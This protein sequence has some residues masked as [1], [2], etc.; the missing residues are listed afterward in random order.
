MSRFSTELLV[1]DNLRDWFPRAA[2]EGTAVHL[3]KATAADIA[4][5]DNA[6][7]EAKAG[8]KAAPERNQ[9]GWDQRG[10]ERPDG[11]QVWP[12]LGN[13]RALRRSTPDWCESLQSR[14][15]LHKARISEQTCGGYSATFACVDL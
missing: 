10:N 7:D 11:N 8:P 5:G 9:K 14:L 2:D 15:C 1:F 4:S 13:F 12:V 6:G 3:K